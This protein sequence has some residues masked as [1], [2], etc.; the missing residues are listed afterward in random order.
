MSPAAP[1]RAAQ[2]RTALRDLDL[3]ATD[4][5]LVAWASRM[6]D[7]P[8]VAVLAGWLD[9]VRAAATSRPSGRQD[10]GKAGGKNGAETVSACPP[11]CPASAQVSGGGNVSV[12]PPDWPEVGRA[13]RP[14]AGQ[15]PARDVRLGDTIVIDGQVH[16]IR[17]FMHDETGVEPDLDGP[18]VYIESDRCAKGDWALIVSAD[19]LLT[20]APELG[21]SVPPDDERC[22]TC[23][24]SD[25]VFYVRDVDDTVS[26]LG[27]Q[28]GPKH[29]W[30]CSRCRRE[31]TTPTGGTEA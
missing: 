13:N 27:E 20:R 29:A 3:D 30:W 6:L 10:S 4:E 26:E 19:T 18:V 31:W 8:T 21:P 2:L 22:R 15:F 24:T 14:L 16:R 17:A 5:R 1:Q 28:P 7:E 23:G 12:W 11:Q 9:R 25:A